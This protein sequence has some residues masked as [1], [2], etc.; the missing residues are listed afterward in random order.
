MTTT[1]P[2]GVVLIFNYQLTN[3]PNYQIVGQAMPLAPQRKQS[4]RNRSHND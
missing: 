4:A 1:V 3:L 2:G